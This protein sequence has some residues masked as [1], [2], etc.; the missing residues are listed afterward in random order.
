MLNLEKKDKFVTEFSEPII[1]NT[2]VQKS[3]DYA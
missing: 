3:G 2:I 1:F